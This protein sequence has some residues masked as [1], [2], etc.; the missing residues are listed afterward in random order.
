MVLGEDTLACYVHVD[1]FAFIGCSS[2][3]VDR[4]LGILVGILE[5]WGFRVQRSMAGTVTRFIGLRPVSWGFVP[6][7]DRL[8]ALSLALWDIAHAR[9]VKATTLRSVI[10]VLVHY[11]LLW[12]P[13]LAILHATFSLMQQEHYYLKV[14]PSVSQELLIFRGLLGYLVLDLTRRI[15]PVVLAQ[16]AA[17]AGP[18]CSTG[19]FA[20]AHGAPAY[21]EVAAVI[22]RVEV[23][24]K[25]IVSIDGLG[26][27]LHIADDQWVKPLHRTVLPRGWF[28]DAVPWRMAMANRWKFLQHINAGETRAYLVWLEVLSKA[29][30]SD[31]LDFLDL[32]DNSCCVGIASRGRSPSWALNQCCRKRAALEAVSNSRLPCTWIGTA[33]QPA[34]GGTRPD[35]YGRLRL[36]PPRWMFA[37]LVLEV[38]AGSARITQACR[39]LGIETSQP[40]DKLGGSR[41]DLT[42]KQNIRKLLNII[43]SGHI[44]LV[45][46]APPCSTFSSA[47][48]WDGGPIPLRDPVDPVY[49]DGGYRV[50]VTVYSLKRGT[51]MRR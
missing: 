12:R 36:D 39:R 15:A 28:S 18:S 10:G 48:R 45:W 11:G 46:L 9:V 44:I 14:W 31:G 21:D 51:G 8:A 7:D 13:S 16:D 43:A 41:F 26:H 40:W 30:E 42:N 4:A 34:D 35:K 32:S 5:V 23:R 29:P 19:A 1:D 37:R 2:V 47:R 50:T 27:D 49:A 17:G 33:F 3:L 38:Y 24:G 25:G 6:T 22:N 20:L